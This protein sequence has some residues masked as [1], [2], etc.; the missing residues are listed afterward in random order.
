ME[1]TVTFATRSGEIK[2]LPVV[3]PVGWDDEHME[4]FITDAVNVLHDGQ[5][6]SISSDQE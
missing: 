1:V 2:T 6:I 5:V 4:Q 3:V